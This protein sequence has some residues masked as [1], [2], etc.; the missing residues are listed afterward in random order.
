MALKNY[1]LPIE[2]FYC[3]QFWNYS[4]VLYDVLL[5]ACN[6]YVDSPIM[7]GKCQE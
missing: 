5:L 6:T 1:H 7:N 2:D 4:Q 3:Y